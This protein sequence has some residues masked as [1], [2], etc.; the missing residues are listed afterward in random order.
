M[1]QAF[2]DIRLRCTGSVF[3]FRP[4]RDEVGSE[5]AFR[6]M[7]GE[8]KL[9]RLRMAGSGNRF[10]GGGIGESFVSDQFIASILPS[11]GEGRNGEPEPMRPFASELDIG[12]TFCVWMRS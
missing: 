5:A 8:A 3:L 2:V 6:P 12:D 11:P 4:R 9:G 7:A 1:A 10:D